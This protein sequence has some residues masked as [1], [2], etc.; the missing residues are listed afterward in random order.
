MKLSQRYS[1]TTCWM[2]YQSCRERL[3]DESGRP[4]PWWGE[5]LLTS[6]VPLLFLLTVFLER[7]APRFAQ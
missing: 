5:L 7:V 1:R 6:M 2:D 4:V 3:E